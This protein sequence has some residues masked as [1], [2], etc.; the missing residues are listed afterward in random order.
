MCE[1]Q[2]AAQVLINARDRRVFNRRVSGMFQD[3]LEDAG[4]ESDNFIEGLD[5]TFKQAVEFVNDVLR[6]NL[7]GEDPPNPV[8]DPT[9]PK[10]L[11]EGA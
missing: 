1:A 6:Y 11:E 10:S 7:D 9:N 2:E 4:Q 3:Y 5:I 8:L